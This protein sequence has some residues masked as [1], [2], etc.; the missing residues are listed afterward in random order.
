[1]NL[2]RGLL[3]TAG[4]ALTDGRGRVRSSAGI[5][6]LPVDFSVIC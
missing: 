5:N 3:G 2:Y 6:I 4:T 1:M